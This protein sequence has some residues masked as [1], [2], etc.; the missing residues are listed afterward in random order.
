M[1]VVKGYTQGREVYG[2]DLLPGGVSV[3]AAY[4]FLEAI[5]ESNG[6]TLTGRHKHHGFTKLSYANTRHGFN[7]NFRGTYFGKWWASTSPTTGRKAP[8][9]Q[10]FDLYGAKELPKGFEHY[11]S[12]DNMFNSQDP[13]TGKALATNPNSPAPIDRADAGRT[14]RIGMRWNFDRKR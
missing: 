12:V 6:R 1:N 14:Y 8:A 7:A 3:N 9:F 13:N 11:A 5:D 2:S 4:T 10:L